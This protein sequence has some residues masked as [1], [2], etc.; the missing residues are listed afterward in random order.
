VRWGEAEQFSF[1]G[2][3]GDTVYGYV[4]KPWNAQPGQQ[5]PVAFIV[6][7]GPQGSFGNSW[8][9]RW[10]PQTYAGA[11]YAAVFIDF[12]GS[13]GYGQKFTDSISNDWGG[14]PLVDLQKGYDA[15]VKKFPWLDRSRD[16]ALGAS[17]G[18]YMMNWIAGN[19]SDEFKC[20][21]NHDG[22]FDT[23]GMAYSTEE[24]W[25]T[26]W[27]NGGPYYKVPENH[28]RFNPVHHVAKWK[29]P[30]LVIQGDLDF[31]IPTAQGLG[32]F[33]AL[34]RQGV[35]SKLL[36]FPDENH[37]VLKPANSVQWHHT[38]NGWLDRFL[39]AQPAK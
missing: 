29:T 17:Y 4:M 27:E 15:A 1:A 9:Y 18:G 26:D 30:M 32:T 36:V 38:V 31:R 37:W 21:V 14:K 25:F 22:V 6:H 23:R 3:N 24:Q 11:G 34:Q 20:I 35:E 13:T 39:K 28:E 5:Y 19:W 2:A 16:C 7:G 8:S 10:N 33:T 12:H